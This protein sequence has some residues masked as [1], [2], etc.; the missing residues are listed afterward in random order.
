MAISISPSNFSRILIS[1]PFFQKS[2]GLGFS[3]V[4]CNS[5]NSLRLS[6]LASDCSYRSASQPR[7]SRYNRLVKYGHLICLIGGLRV[8]G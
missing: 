1:A 8:A 2:N 4:L 7:R 3:S 5:V 6:N